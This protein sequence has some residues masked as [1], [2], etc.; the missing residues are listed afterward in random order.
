MILHWIKMVPQNVIT[1]R[2]GNLHSGPLKAMANKQT[3]P[4]V[5]MDSKT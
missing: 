1:L 4:V 3:A 2:Y 5:A